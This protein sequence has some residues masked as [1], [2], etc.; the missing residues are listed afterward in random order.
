MT[1]ALLL[2]ALTAPWAV[3][4]NT[5]HFFALNEFRYS[6]KK[7]LIL[8]I[9]FMLPLIAVVLFFYGKFG[10]ERGGQLALLFYIMPQIIF[11]Y[12]LSRYRDGRFFFT[13]FFTSGISIFIIQFSNL[14]DYYSTSEN[15]IVLFLLRMTLY[16]LALFILVTRFREPYKHAMNTIHIGWALFAVISALYTIILLL[17]F[18]FPTTLSTR[19]EDIP[20]LAI[21]FILMIL[22]YQHFISSLLR[23]Q[24]DYHEKEQNQLLEIQLKMMQ[25][26]MEQTETAMRNTEIYR[27]DLRH[28]LNTVAGMLT[29]NQTEEAREYIGHSI[30]ELDNTEIRNWCA[31]PVLNAMFASYFSYAETKK[32]KIEAA[33]DIPAQ[34]DLDATSLSVVFANAIENAIHAVCKLPEEERIIRCKCIR[35]PKFMFSISNPYIGE[36]LLDEKGIPTSDECEHGIGILSILAYCEKNDAEC[37]F[38]IEDQWFSIRIVKN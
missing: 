17:I 20:V 32:I 21:T 23:Q 30:S 7:S 19:P 5:A 34:L 6:K 11:F 26:R 12:I 31:N 22:T 4:F 35:H 3:I 1:P 10:S 37:D 25:Q 14:I 15:H 16:P 24:K 9:C 13:F 27:H 38:K 2:K 8:T 28:R 18:N 29:R 36:I 33:L